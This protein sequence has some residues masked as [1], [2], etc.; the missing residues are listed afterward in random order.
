MFKRILDEYFAFNQQQRKGLFVLAC[1]CLALF[2]L[3]LLL[4][5]F[6]QPGTIEIKQLPV[7]PVQKTN[8]FEGVANQ[9]SSAKM[10]ADTFFVNT[11]VAD[12]L[13]NFDPNTISEANLRRL[14]FNK[15]T[16]A[17]FIQFRK[18]GIV[19]KRKSDLKKV[20][21][22]GDVLYQKLE[23][24]INLPSAEK[25]IKNNLNK[26]TNL[27]DLNTADSV[28]FEKLEFLDSRTVAQI[29]KYRRKLGG[30]I[31]YEQLT[32]VFGM[33]KKTADKIS[34]RFRINRLNVQK[35]A[36]QTVELKELKKHPYVGVVMAQKIVALRTHKN[37]QWA[38]VA[39][40][41]GNEDNVKRLRPYLLF[42]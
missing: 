10:A 27:P 1:I 5:V 19:F 13:F 42:D 29:L 17:T 12:T 23:P 18:Q 9:D 3:R 35:I 21:G 31:L 26:K 41:A 14:G 32:E 7:L 25:W 38:D 24:Y 37:L 20:Y 11:V 39:E 8:G 33:D 40:L 28:T 22:V 16:A 2:V 6:I 34:K 30:F 15:K 4:P 36:V